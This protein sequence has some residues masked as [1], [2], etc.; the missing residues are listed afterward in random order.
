M[1][2]FLAAFAGMTVLLGA[3]AA[4]PAEEA[5]ALVEQAIKASGGAEKLAKLKA[6]SWKSKGRT[7]KDEATT[8]SYTDEAY[9]QGFDQLRY[10]LEI[11]EN[12]RTGK[13]LLVVNGKKA[14]AQIGDKVIEGKEDYLAPRSTAFYVIR[15]PEMLLP[16]LEKESKLDHCGER[17][18]D[19][20]PCRGVRVN[21]EG[22][23]EVSM[24]F[25]KETGL[26]VRSEASITVNGDGGHMMVC[27]PTEYKDFDG[28]KHFTKLAIDLDGNRF[29]ELELTEL[30]L[31]GQLEADVFA[32]P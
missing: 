8:A 10:N 28:V 7:V 13:L 2:T 32:K 14:W 5:R 17:K 4:E 22:W 29:M 31:L 23:P 11:T 27:T 16:M 30:K 18:I 9:L 3:S 24:F 20:R 15:L 6:V 1:R 25:D 21:R 12:G 19:S 26:V